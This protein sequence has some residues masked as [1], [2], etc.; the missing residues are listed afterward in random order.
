[1]SQIVTYVSE[2]AKFRGMTGGL[3]ARIAIKTDINPLM[4]AGDR[5]SLI[6]LVK[7][8]MQKHSRENI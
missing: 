1:M 3:R 8:L 6:I 7:Y 5:H 4:S 2:E